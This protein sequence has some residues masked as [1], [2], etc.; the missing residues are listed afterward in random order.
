MAC[1]APAKA[2]GLFPKKG[3]LLPGAD[4]DIVIVDLDRESEIEAAR[5]HSIGRAT[6]FEGFRT[7]GLPVTTIVRGH[8]VAQDGE[9]VGK[10]GWGKSVI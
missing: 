5:L 4:A 1:E 10:P 8:V 7:K 6:P 3:V 2:F 9:P